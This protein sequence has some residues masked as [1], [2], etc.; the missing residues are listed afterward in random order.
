MDEECLKA[1]DILKKKLISAP[2]I[3]AP[4]WNQNFELMCDASNYAIGAVLGQRREKKGSENVIADQLSR[5]VNNEVTSKETKIWESFSNETL[6]YIQQ[7][8]WF[9]D[10]A[11]FKAASV[12]SED[13]NWQQRKKF[14]HD[15]KQFVWD[16]PYL[17]KIGADNLLRHCVTKEEVEGILWHC[18]DSPYGGHFSGERTTT[19]LAKVLKHYGVRHKVAIPYHPQTNGQAEVSNREIKR[20]LEKTVAT[21]RKDW[22]QKLDDALWAYRTAM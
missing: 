18:Y 8:S 2:V 4:D 6:M 11:N 3:I 12:I 16:D 21:S 22:S 14:L 7:R 5:L 19:K 13:L 20:I 10:M 15:A 9:A 17:F 1:F